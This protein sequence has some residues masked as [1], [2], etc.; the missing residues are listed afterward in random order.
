MILNYSNCFSV[1]DKDQKANIDQTKE[2]NINDYSLITHGHSDHISIT[3]QKI[4]TT[5]ETASFIDLYTKREMSYSF[6]NG[7]TLNLTDNI[8]LSALDAG[9]ILGS[10]MFYLESKDKSVLY[11]GDF[12]MQDS[13]LLKA[14][15][16]KE[17][18]IL[19]LETTFGKKE[20]S[21]PR[22]EQ[23][24]EDFAEMITKDIK[25]NRLVLIGAYSLGKSQE[26]IRFVN[27]YLK[28]TPLVT[29][30]AFEFSKIYED[31]NVSLGKYKLL[32]HNIS[33]HN[34]L[35]VPMNLINRDLIRCLEHQQNRKV[36]SYLAT[37]WK[38]YRSGKC[39]PI[40]DHCDYQDLLDFVKAVNPKKV[41]TMHGFANEFSKTI[42]KELGIWSRPITDLSQIS[43]SDFF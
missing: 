16:P 4:F 37:G 3:N 17:A 22:R 31:F 29:K 39:I 12:K 35:I 36:S 27:D 11:T 19:I 21:F 20:F 2:T 26:L 28:E 24:Y 34:I 42:N 8:N 10:K 32:D 9:H 38:H 5:K 13:L 43:I 14:A 33:E 7:N 30:K 23:V 1:I 15:T 18:D 25:N 6:V 41:F 40:S